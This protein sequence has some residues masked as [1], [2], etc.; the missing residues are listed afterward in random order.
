MEDR[1]FDA[2]ARTAG[3]SATRRVVLGLV[4]GLAGVGMSRGAEQVQSKY[5]KGRRAR[6]QAAKVAKV[7]ICH[8]TGSETNPYTIIEVSG[9]ASAQH[10]DKHGDFAVNVEDGCCLDSDCTEFVDSYCDESAAGGAQCA[11]TTTDFTPIPPEACDA[12]DP[13]PFPC[14]GAGCGRA[15]VGLSDLCCR[16]SSPNFNCQKRRDT[17]NQIVAFCL[18]QR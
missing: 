1:R 7:R 13:P 18:P 2:L 15:F 14:T 17:D 16:R 11:C 8:S 5:R 6:A 9:N 12:P 3:G 4:A 10:F